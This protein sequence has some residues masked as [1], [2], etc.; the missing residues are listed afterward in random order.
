MGGEKETKDAVDV[1]DVEN[2]PVTE[3]NR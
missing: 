3:A 2:G 1:S